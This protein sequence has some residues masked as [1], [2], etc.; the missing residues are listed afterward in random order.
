MPQQC[1]FQRACE[2]CIIWNLG[3]AWPSQ[4]RHNLFQDWEKIQ[5]LLR[6]VDTSDTSSCQTW[7]ASSYTTATYALP[8]SLVFSTPLSN[9]QKQI[10]S[11]QSPT[12][13]SC[14][15]RDLPLKNL[16]TSKGLTLSMLIFDNFV[17]WSRLELTEVSSYL[18]A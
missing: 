16:F 9:P 17:T 15:L 5:I 14:T 12:N 2:I 6:N 7:S 13:L 10:Y 18:T 4:H 3:T 11:V 8:L 1:L